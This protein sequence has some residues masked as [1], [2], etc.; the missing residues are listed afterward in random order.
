MGFVNDFEEISRKKS[1]KFLLFL[2][3]NYQQL[4]NFIVKTYN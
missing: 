3:I 2:H 4:N 1:R